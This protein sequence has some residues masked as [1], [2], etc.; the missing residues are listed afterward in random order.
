MPKEKK[1]KVTRIMRVTLDED[2]FEK[3]DKGI[4]HSDSG[5]RNES[6]KLSAL[7]D[8]EPISEDDLPRREVIRTR[9]VY[10]QPQDQAFGQM[11]KQGIKEAA[12][13]RIMSFVYDVVYYPE[14]RAELWNRAKGLYHNVAEQVQ[15]LSKSNK[16]DGDHSLPQRYHPEEVLY[17]VETVNENNERIVVTGEQA[18]MLVNAMQ[19]KARELS[20]MIFLLSNIVVKDDK[21]DSDY[22]LEENFIKQLASEEATKTMKNLVAQ[23]QLLDEGTAICLSDYLN[24]YV[25]YEDRLIPIPAFIDDG[26]AKDKEMLVEKSQE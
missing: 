9:N 6:G 23:K 24:G 2:E 21:N 5:L 8:I 14:K 3:Y 12:Y 19:Q 15:S 7:P 17:E 1:K 26:T 4:T 16:A 25:R 18:E 10:V 20:A 11:L 22:V 13:Q